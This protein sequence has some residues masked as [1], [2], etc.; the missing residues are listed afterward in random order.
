V[1]AWPRSSAWKRQTSRTETDESTTA[2]MPKPISARLPVEIAVATA[3]PP[4]I[5]FQTTVNAL[6]SIALRASDRDSG[7]ADCSASSAMPLIVRGGC[8][9]AVGSRRKR[10]RRPCTW[11]C[12]RNRPTTT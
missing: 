10:L 8:G 11:P 6:S 3:A 12:R 7:S 4:T 9:E 2:L 5:V 1:R